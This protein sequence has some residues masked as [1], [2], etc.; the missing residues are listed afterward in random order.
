MNAPA[1]R[2]LFGG[3]TF[4]CLLAG[5]EQDKATTNERILRIRELGKRNP[6]VLPALTQYLS[7]PNADIRIETVKSIVRIGTERSLD[8]LVQ[9]TKDKDEEVE[10]RATDGIVNFYVPN[11]VARRGLSGSLTRG[12]R[13]IRSYFASRNDQ[14]IDPSVQVRPD[15]GSCAQ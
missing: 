3:L 11:Y 5:Q 13:Q 15:V 1:L 2:L 9:A 7:D 6:A 12:V 8:P 14:V 4:A 10:I